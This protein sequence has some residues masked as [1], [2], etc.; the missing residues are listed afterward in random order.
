MDMNETPMQEVID[1]L[2]Q[3]LPA[4][5]PQMQR[6]AT[7]IL[8]NPGS[9]AVLVAVADR[10]LNS[11]PAR[12]VSSKAPWNETDAFTSTRPSVWSPC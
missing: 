1:A 9:V 10:S 3:E 11:Q 8:D 7:V 6:A 2:S 4:L 5:S 12:L